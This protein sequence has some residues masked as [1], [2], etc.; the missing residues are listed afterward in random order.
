MWHT[1]SNVEF[2]VCRLICGKDDNDCDKGTAFLISPKRVLTATHNIV[3]YIEDNATNITLEFLNINNERD[4]RHAIPIQ[5]STVGPVI[6]LELD[7]PVDKAYLT[8]SSYPIETDDEF[9]TFGYP[10]VKW[11]TGQWTR[12]KISR[13][14]ENDVYNPYDW[15]I[16]LDHQSKIEDFSG[17]SGAPLLVD[18]QLVG[19]LLTEALEKG[20]A[21]SLG[22]VGLSKFSGLLEELEIE[23]YEYID[24]Y[25]YQ[26]NEGDYKDFVFIEKLEAAQILQHE[27][28]QKEFY[29]A[30]ILTNIVKSKSVKKEVNELNRLKEDIRGLWHTKYVGYKDE[31]DG[32]SLLSSVYER[33]E[34]HHINSLSTGINISLYAKKGILHQWA[35]EC[36]VG[37]VKNY[38][39]NLIEYRKAKGGI[40]NE[41]EDG[42]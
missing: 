21:I 23:T 39:R 28:C 15:N 13:I 25:E 7:N 29:H 9:E 33:V 41:R 17:L 18:G 26:P 20:K 37:W 3:R 10:A 5:T 14:L 12:N 22:A 30:E 42:D 24:P 8:F 6:V 35:D 16:D 31:H 2:S 34:D 32:S 19:V 1:K 11:S 27:I 36:K 4:V 40:T 38:E